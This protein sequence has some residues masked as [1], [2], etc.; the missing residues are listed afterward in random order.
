VLFFYPVSYQIPVYSAKYFSAMFPFFILALACAL[1]GLLRLWKPAL[2]GGLALIIG[3][4]GWR[5]AAIFTQPDHQRTDWRAVAQYLETHTTLQDVILVFSDYSTYALERYYTGPAKTIP[6]GADPYQPEDFYDYLQQEHAMHTLWLVLHHDQA[7]APHHRL[8]EAAGARY[9]AITGL[10]PNQGQITVLGYSATW[11]HAH[12]PAAAIPVNARFENG[13]ALIGYTVDATRLRATD[14]LFHPPSNWIH[15]TTYWQ[16]EDTAPPLNFTPFVRLVDAQG[17]IWGG[18]LQRIPTMF[19]FTP[20][21]I[22]EPGYI[23]EA[24]YDV[25]LNPI[26][27]PGFYKLIVGLEQEIGVNILLTDQTSE[28]ILTSIEI[29][30]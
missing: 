25:N 4:A 24:H 26:T 6:F 30:K 7:M 1:E 2:W 22:W 11:H 29:I 15:I 18:E 27:P 9:P 16:V 19:H 20:P 12:L 28:I 23:M 3:F 13:L 5:N 21:E 17:G 8:S 14:R 10:Y